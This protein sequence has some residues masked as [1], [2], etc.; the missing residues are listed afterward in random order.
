MTVCAYILSCSS[1]V[2]LFVTS[3]TVAHQVPRSMGFPRQ[4]HWSGLPCPP[5]R[6][7]PDPGVEPA[8]LCLLH[9]Q[10]DFFITSTTWEVPRNDYEKS[11]K[12]ALWVRGGF[13]STIILMR[14]FR[15]SWLSHWARTNIWPQE[16]RCKCAGKWVMPMKDFKHL[17]KRQA[18]KQKTEYAHQGRV[19]AEENASQEL[20]K[21]A[22]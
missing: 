7:L 20:P 21:W 19:K 14:T 3:Q 15:I 10:T 4:E 18:I 12:Y 2:Q 5:L 22:A 11:T 1:H 16:L 6:D 17:Q 9:R 8:S 13:R